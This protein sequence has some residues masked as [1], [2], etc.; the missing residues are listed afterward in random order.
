ML[1]TMLAQ[2]DFFQHQHHQKEMH[3]KFDQVYHM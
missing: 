2:P 3:I 1:D